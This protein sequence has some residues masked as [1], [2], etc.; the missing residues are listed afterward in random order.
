MKYNRN[1][2]YEILSEFT[3][4]C[5]EN[6]IWYSAT[7]NTLLGVA[8]HG[9]FVPWHEKIEVMMT[10]E[11]YRKL[12]RLFPK[13]VI[14]SSIINNYKNLQAA[15]VKDAETW[16]VHTP[17]IEIFI[18]VPT[19]IKKI[20]KF[21]SILLNIKNKVLFKRND[22]RNVIDQLFAVRN[23]GFFLI[24]NK[25]AS[26]SKYWIHNLSFQT[27]IKKFGPL[28]IEVIVWIWELY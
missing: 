18:L 4:I 7:N 3:K 17:F 28:N 25:S 11:S 9:G 26:L 6:M 1:K 5:K 27:V 20:K 24:V 23:E 19:T 15:F 16:D 22:L 8:R 14:D 12:L 2:A 10:P 13:N 21:K